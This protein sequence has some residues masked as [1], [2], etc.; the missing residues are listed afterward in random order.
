MPPTG[1]FWQE[2]GL[3]NYDKLGPFSNSLAVPSRFESIQ[4]VLAT[5]RC[6]PV[7]RESEK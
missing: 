6:K 7:G 2:I 5:I 3:M 4:P 1:L